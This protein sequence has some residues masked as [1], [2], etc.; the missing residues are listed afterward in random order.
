MEVAENKILG[1]LIV[2]LTRGSESERNA[3][4]KEIY[5]IMSHI[6]YK[7][8]NIYYNNKE[9]VEDSIQNLMFSIFINANKYTTNDNACGWI[10]RVYRNTFINFAKKRKKERAILKKQVQELRD[11]AATFEAYSEK[12][13]LYNY[14]FSV[15]NKNETELLIYRY[16][17][18]VSIGEIAK[19]FN[20]PKSTIEYQLKQLESKIRKL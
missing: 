2:E 5:S 15:L 13:I 10:M 4:I 7:V 1:E 19:E 20:K 17:Y 16:F 12:F 6:F 3:A 14:I 11:R 9:D 8:G 18:D